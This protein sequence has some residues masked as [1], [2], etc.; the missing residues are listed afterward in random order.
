MPKVVITYQRPEKIRQYKKQCEFIDCKER[1]TIVEATT[2][3]GKTVGCIVWLFEKSLQG[4]DGD[5]YWW[6][7]PTFPVAKIAFRR[8][9]RY[10]QP[11][12]VFIKNESELSITLVTGVRIFFKSADNPD[13][14]YGEDVRAAVFDEATRAKQDSWFA[15][16]TTLTATNGEC[17]IIGNVKGT[18]NWVY[19]LAREAET[20]NKKDWAYFKITAARQIVNTRNY[21]SY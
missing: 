15:L 10:I 18:N 19:K 7:A 20:G 1:F 14:L 17:K 5:N 11:K 2:K 8:M 6:V 21:I 16:F 3:A 13:G 9:C 12:G 4:R